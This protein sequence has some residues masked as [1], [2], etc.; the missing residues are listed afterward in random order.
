VLFEEADTEKIK[1][2]VLNGDGASWIKELANTAIKHYQLDR[3]RI[4]QAIYKN[5]YD[6]KEA[7]KISKMIKNLQIQKALSHI[8]KLKYDCGGEVKEVK[9]LEKLQNYLQSNI[10]GLIPYKLRED[11]QLPE[12]PEGVFY[13]DLGTMEHNVCDVIYIRMKGRKMSWSIKGG[14]NLSKILAL[15]ASGKLYK[16]IR[17]LLS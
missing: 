16:A 11:I 15:K 17:D 9:K 10:D 2:R 13:K 4:Y 7:R 8:E 5:V 3:F 12:P 14:T 6:K 1:L